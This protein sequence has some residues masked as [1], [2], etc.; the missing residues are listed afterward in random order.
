MF[1]L[2]ELQFRRRLDGLRRLVETA[3]F[4]VVISIHIRRAWDVVHNDREV[5]VCDD[6]DDWKK[7]K[8]DYVVMS[9]EKEM[10]YDP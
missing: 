10:L 8:E 1:V 7:K 9:A 2:V 4:L 5:H 3:S 6:D